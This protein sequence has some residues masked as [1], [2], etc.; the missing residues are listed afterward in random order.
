MMDFVLHAMSF[1]TITTDAEG[2]GYDS[3]KLND[4]VNDFL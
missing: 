2:S 1:S 3:V 4:Q